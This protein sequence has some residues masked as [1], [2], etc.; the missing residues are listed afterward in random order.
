MVRQL[1]QDLD[2]MSLPKNSTWSRKYRN[3]ITWNF[4]SQIRAYNL[5]VTSTM[6]YRLSY[7]GSPRSN[8]CVCVVLFCIVH[9]LCCACV[10]V[11]QK[12]KQ[13]SYFL[14]KFINFFSIDFIP[15]FFSIKR[16]IADYILRGLL[17]VIYKYA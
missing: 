8:V 17:E 16:D 11:K 13:I 5:L 15:I 9:V 6:L 2:S 1:T 12:N 3:S 10:C 14:H 4:Q 7:R